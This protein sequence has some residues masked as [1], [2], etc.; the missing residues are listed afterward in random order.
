[1]TYDQ[2]RLASPDDDADERDRLANLQ[3][4]KEEKA[5]RDADEK[6]ERNRDD[7]KDRI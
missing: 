3:A 5:E 1:M 6:Y 2:W 4:A 7:W